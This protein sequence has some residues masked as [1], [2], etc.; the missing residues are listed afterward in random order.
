MSGS[1]PRDDAAPPE[2]PGEPADAGPRQRFDPP[3]LRLR[4]TLEAGL[5]RADLVAGLEART[6]WDPHTVARMLAH[7]GVHLDGHPHGGDDL[8]ARLTA[9]TRVDLH[10]LAWEPEPIEIGPERILAE[11]E[12]WL[13]VDK[14]AWLPVQPA[15]ASRRFAL[16]PLLRAHTGCAAL[17][18]V[19][20][21]DRETSGVVLFARDA[22]A[23]ARLGAVFR[24]HRACRSY[25]ALVAPPPARASFEVAGFLGRRIDPTRYRFALRSSP[26]P[27]YRFSHTRFRLVAAAEG[28]ALLAAAPVTGR[29]HQIRVHLEAA[30]APVVGDPLYGGAPAPRLQLHARELAFPDRGREV[31]LRAPLP[32]DLEPTFHALARS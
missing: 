30:G 32:D 20:R 2:R 29:T 15:R 26:A 9:G 11:G 13:A 6:G 19:H 28:S 16:E 1:P 5:P 25:R 4:W 31:V 12:D 18:A 14:P 17:V 24:E 23:A 21:L 22:R 8:P 7:G 27:R 10:A 3:V